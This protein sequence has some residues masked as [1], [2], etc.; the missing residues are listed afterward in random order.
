[1][2]NNTKLNEFV[3]K[4]KNILASTIPKILLRS[5]YFNSIIIIS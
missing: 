5:V 1:M 3:F 2:K 4:Y